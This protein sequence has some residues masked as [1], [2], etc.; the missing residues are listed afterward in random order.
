MTDQSIREDPERDELI[1]ELRAVKR[2]SQERVARHLGISQQRVSQIEERI[3]AALPGPDKAKMIRDSVELH[4]NIIRRMH[5]LAD[6]EGAPVTSGKDGD[7]VRDPESDAV[8]RDYSGRVNAYRLALAAEAELRKL[9][10]LD[11]ATKTES[12]ATVRYTLEGVDPA[13]LA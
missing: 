1:W 5:E 8:V 7:I 3:R 11:A 4:A 2:W 10:G 9:I 6:M 12:T 13:D